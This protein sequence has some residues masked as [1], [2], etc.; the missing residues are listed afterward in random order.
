[1]FS[2]AWIKKKISIYFK[3][4]AAAAAAAAAKSLQSCPKNTEAILKIWD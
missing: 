1:M 2:S 4:T 3:N